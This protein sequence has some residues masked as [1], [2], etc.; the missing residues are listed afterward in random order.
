MIVDSGHY[1]FPSLI[2]AGGG[3][4]NCSLKIGTDATATTAG[5]T[6]LV[7]E[8]DSNESPTVAAV[9][10]D[11][12]Y[13]V[14]Q[15]KGAFGPGG[16]YT[17]SEAGMFLNGVMYA[18]IIGSVSKVSGEYI[19]S[20]FEPKFTQVISN[21]YMPTVGKEFIP[22]YVAAGGGTISVSVKIGT[23]TTA[24]SAGMT[25]LV[26]PV[27]TDSSPTVSSSGATLYVSAVF[28]PSGAYTI[29]EYGYFL[30]ATTP[31]T[32]LKQRWVGPPIVK[33]DGD[34]VTIYISDLFQEAT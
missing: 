31:G 28:G 32:A 11:S 3:A 29:Q 27:A 16:T 1:F 14:L 8:V 5:M 26:T 20:S 24:S 33:N 23:G 12:A 6:D 19:N 7:S 22:R 13:D 15:V 2:S 17:A 18:R 25:D 21:G 4:V 9:A 10:G 30:T 34:Y